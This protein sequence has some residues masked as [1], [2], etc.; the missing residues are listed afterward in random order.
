M[1][2]VTQYQCDPDLTEILVRSSTDTVQWLCRTTGIRFV[3]KYGVSAV[4]HE[5]RWK[6]AGGSVIWVVGGGRGLIDGEYRAADKHG[7]DVRYNAR[8]TALLRGRGGVEGV[9][10]EVD[11]VMEEIST[12]TVV[13]ACGGFESNR[14]WRAQYLGPGWDLAKVRGTRYN[15]G[16]GI[17]MALDVGAQ[18]YGHWSGCHATSWERYSPDYGELSKPMHGHRDGFHLS[19]M[20]NAEGRRFVDEG[21]DFRNYTY[22]KYGRMIMQQPGS[23]AWQVFDAQMRSLRGE[24]YN[25][26][27]AT[28]VQADT[29]EQLA[30]RMA[31]VNRDQFLKTVREY[32]SAIRR[33]VPFNAAIKD[34]RCTVGLAINKSNW[35][36]ALEVPPFDA[37]AVGTGITFTFGGLKITTDAE[38]LDVADNLIPGLYS[39]GELVGGIFYF[40]YAGGAGLMAGSVYGRRAGASAG[41]YALSPT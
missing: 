25:L 40:N 15:T 23:H 3:P 7:I 11:G 37:Y 30:E 38:V 41:R 4:K 36:S 12:R 19:L 20:I 22:A 2:R 28:K 31:D 16:D 14:A 6:F 1:G 27:G 29:L 33:E 26:K 9:R 18:P 10:V 34:G 13:L 39:A 17:R 8:A 32:N 21:A 35:A 5:G 24:D